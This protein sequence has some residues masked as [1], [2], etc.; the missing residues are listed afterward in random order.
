[1]DLPYT[2]EASTP[3]YIK[4]AL[5]GYWVVAPVGITLMAVL[6]DPAQGLLQKAAIV[7][8]LTIFL[9]YLHGM[10]IPRRYEI[11]YDGIRVYF[12]WP[13]HAAFLFRDGLEIS[14][15]DVGGRFTSLNAALDSKVRSLSVVNA[16]TGGGAGGAS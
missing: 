6:D 1:M 4:L 15:G 10:R 11:S 16:G 5:W 14:A 8:G 9:G 7:T 12:G 13:R 3:A 2:V